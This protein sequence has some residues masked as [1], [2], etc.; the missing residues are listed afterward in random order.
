V[1]RRTWDGL[2]GIGDDP[3]L[4]DGGT[5]TPPRWAIYGTKEQWEIENHGIDPDIEVE[6]DPKL[7][8]EDHDPKLEKA[9]A[10]RMSSL[11]EH[12]LPTYPKP[13]YP[14]FH[15]RFSS[16]VSWRR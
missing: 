9:A 14:N 10:V 15:P 16:V 7:V 1:G 2:V 6:L 8:R 13:E 12:R 3:E 4:L 11:K 5:V